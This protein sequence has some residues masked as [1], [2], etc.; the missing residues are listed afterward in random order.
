MRKKEHW[1]AI[2]GGCVGAVFT[3]VVCSSFPIVAQSQGDN[4]GEITCTGLRVVNA[5]GTAVIR[6]VGSESGGT[7]MVFE[8]SVPP[9]KWVSMHC[10]REYSEFSIT[11]GLSALVRVGADEKGGSVAVYSQDQ[12]DHSTAGLGVGADGGMVSVFGKE[13]EGGMAAL[14]T[15]RH[16]GVVSVFGKGEHRSWAYL[17]NDEHGGRVGVLGKGETRSEASISINQLGIGGLGVWDKNG[18]RL[19]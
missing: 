7:I 16:G 14:T 3:M 17:G 5:K 9:F 8:D 4:F 10:D 13:K 12:A 1:Y 19:K 6:L 18:Y 15:D 2:I 11:N